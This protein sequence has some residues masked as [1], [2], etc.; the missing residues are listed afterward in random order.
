MP[1][2]KVDGLGQT[3]G[4]DRLRDVQIE[5]RIQRALAILLPRMGGYCYRGQI[6]LTCA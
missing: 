2:E 6:R 3:A 4:I 1:R 5:S